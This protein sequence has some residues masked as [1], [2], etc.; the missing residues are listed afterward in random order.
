V[1]MLSERGL[2]V[3]GTDEDPVLVGAELEGVPVYG[4]DR[5]V[6]MIERCDAAVLTGMIVSTETMEEIIDA[7]RRTGT[8]LVMFCETGANLCEE[9]VKLGVDSAV[10]EPFPFYIFS[11]TTRIEVYRRK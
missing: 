5:T 3:M 4:E 6:E 1:R 10:A 11:G 8:K 9:Y 7:A 2:D